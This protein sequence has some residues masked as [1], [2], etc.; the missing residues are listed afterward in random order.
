[1]NKN[2]SSFSDAIVIIIICILLYNC[3][4]TNKVENI[5]HRFL[6]N[7]GISQKIE[8]FESKRGVYHE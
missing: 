7:I 4:C 2:N 8:Q 5:G 6:S 1:M 3:I